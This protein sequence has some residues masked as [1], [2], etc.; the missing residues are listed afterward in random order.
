MKKKPL[1]F[2]V[3]RSKE[4]LKKEIA[5]SLSPE[6]RLKKLTRMIRFNKQ[7]SKH[8]YKAVQKRLKEGNTFILK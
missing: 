7:F 6:E 4:E 1:P 8:Y 5:S 2:E 3:Y